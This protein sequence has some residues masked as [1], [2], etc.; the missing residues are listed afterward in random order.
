MSRISKMMSIIISVKS[1]AK[2]QGMENPADRSLRVK[3]VSLSHV[4]YGG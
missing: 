4:E 3:D 2:L 1:V